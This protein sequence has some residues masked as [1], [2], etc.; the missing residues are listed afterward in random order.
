MASVLLGVCCRAG[1][2][3]ESFGLYALFD[4]RSAS[5]ASSFSGIDESSQKDVSMDLFYNVA[6]RICTSNLEC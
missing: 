5:S 1:S 6:I 2:W 4:V 3:I